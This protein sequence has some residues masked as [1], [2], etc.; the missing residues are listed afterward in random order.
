MKKYVLITVL[1]IAQLCIGCANYPDKIPAAYISPLMYKNYTC[2]ELNQEYHRLTLQC[3]A[4]TI[5]QTKAAKHDAT[6]VCIGLAFFPVIPLA[7]DR[8]HELAQ[9]KGQRK[10]I[11]DVAIEKSCIK[12][13]K[14]IKK[15]KEE[16]AIRKE[17]AEKRKLRYDEGWYD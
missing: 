13:T 14:I 8:G 10:T 9:I 6:A 3:S 5:T 11:E 12:L 7:A 1:C 4:L 16:K 15:I 17:K 2:E